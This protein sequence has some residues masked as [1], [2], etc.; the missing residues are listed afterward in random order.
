MAADPDGTLLVWRTPDG[1]L[2]CC[3]GLKPEGG[4]V[5]YLGSLAVDPREQK[6]AFGRR[7]LAAA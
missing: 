6:R 5:W 1:A 3:V 7:L 4:G 2:L